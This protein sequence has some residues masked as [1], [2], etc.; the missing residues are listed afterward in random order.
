MILG[1]SEVSGSNYADQDQLPLS[2]P[3]APKKASDDALRV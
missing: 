3:A 2:A 1:E